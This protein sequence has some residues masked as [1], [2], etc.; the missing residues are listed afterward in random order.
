[1]LR[2]RGE[3][4]TAL[5]N[6]PTEPIMLLRADGTVIS[7]NNAMLG[8]LGM[9]TGELVG[10][11][12]FDFLPP[13]VAR[14]RRAR[15]QQVVR[16]GKPLRFEDTHGGRILDSHVYPILAPAG[17]VL[18]AAVYIHDITDRKRAEDDLRHS[19]ARYRSLFNHAMI[20]VCEATLDGR[21][22]VA[23]VAMARMFGYDTPEQLLAEV[24]DVAQQLYAA[25]DD[26][27]EILCEL[28][29][30]GVVLPREVHARRRDGTLFW[31]L[32]SSRLIRGAE[33]KA[34][35][36]HAAFVD[37]TRRKQAEEALQ[38][39]HD[40]L[41]QK[42]KERTAKLRALTVQLNQTEEQE[43]HRI[44]K[45]LHED[46][47]Q[48]V[49]GSRFALSQLKERGDNKQEREVLLQK[50]NDYLEKAHQSIHSLCLDLH[51]PILHELGLSGGLQWLQNDVKEK[52]GLAVDMAFDRTVEPISATLRSFAF[53]AVRELLF[54]VVKH[55]GVKSAQVRVKP[56]NP[57]SIQIEVEDQGVGFDPSQVKPSGFGLFSIRDR[58]DFL[59]G[60]AEISSARGTGSLIRLI[61]PR[62]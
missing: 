46:L 30:K 42:V 35:H 28:Q 49:A 23:N 17:K 6:A 27:K 37:I 59:G 62:S 7:A 39:A 32:V 13:E 38:K 43:Q 52:F 16:S 56:V 5:V 50:V 34:R 55:A 25:S 26:R 9:T 40:E 48:I 18:G 2:E 14:Y 29:A 44:A 8:R 1:M 20:G 57:D 10:H 51:P 15:L 21:L 36:H 45:I 19:E 22:N 54:N 3:M 53:Q 12:V 33:G 41:E 61:L 4:L 58:V 31:V 47:Q 11:R 60:Q 24:T